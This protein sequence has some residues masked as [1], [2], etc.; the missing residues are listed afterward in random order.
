M[1]KMRFRTY[2]FYLLAISVAVPLLVLTYTQYR[3][4]EQ[5]I[6]KENIFISQDAASLANNVSVRIDAV[7]SLVQMAANVLRAEG[8]KNPQRLTQILSGLRDSLP[9]VQ[10]LHFDTPAGISV[11]ADPLKGADGRS[12]VGAD[13]SDQDHWLHFQGS[14]GIWVSDVIQVKSFGNVPMVFVAS[15]ALG[16]DG[17][18]VGYVVATLDLPELY[19]YITSGIQLSDSVVRVLDRRGIPVFASDSKG[20]AKALIN[21]SELRRIIN[22]NKKGAHIIYRP[23]A[24]DLVGALE[25][26]PSLGWVVGVFQ[27]AEDRETAVYSMVATNVLL[28]LLLLFLIAV[29]ATLGGR[30]LTESVSKLI[31]QVR[32]GR[33]VPTE[34]EK[35]TSPEELVEL[36]KTFCRLLAK[37]KSQQTELT[38]LQ[39]SP[40]S[41]ISQEARLHKDLADLYSSVL[42]SVPVPVAVTD[43]NGMVRFVNDASLPILANPGQGADFEKV[44]RK[45]FTSAEMRERWTDANDITLTQLNTGR[46]YAMYR[47][48]FNVGGRQRSVFTF[49]TQPMRRQGILE[50]LAQ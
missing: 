42:N 40:I 29:I 22:E 25:Q 48:S 15:P 33:P 46:K 19:R 2:L 32:E 1:K 23:D 26:I 17:K 41:V 39:E 37:L 14:D 43:G 50:A 38:K 35:V 10:S 27:R 49:V 44:L 28:F 18:V 20:L 47:T 30:P 3:V 8:T 12:N 4:I 34:E 21:P 7:V 5:N 31:T 6:E 24:S 9:Y 13:H 36:Q 16:T 11:A 45:N